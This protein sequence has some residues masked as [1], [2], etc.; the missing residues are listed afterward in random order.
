M[1]QNV[2]SGP[3][4]L[5]FTEACHGIRPSF[6]AVQGLQTLCAVFFGVSGA[7][8]HASCLSNYHAS[9]VSPRAMH[10]ARTLLHLATLDRWH[11]YCI[12][13]NH[14]TGRLHRTTRIVPA[15]VN[16]FPSV[17]YGTLMLARSLLMRGRHDPC[18]ARVRHLTQGSIGR[19]APRATRKR[20]T[21]HCTAVQA[22]LRRNELAFGTA[23]AL[24]LR[25]PAHWTTL[26]RQGTQTTKPLTHTEANPQ[27]YQPSGPS[28]AHTRTPRHGAGTPT[29]R[30]FASLGTTT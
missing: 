9:P 1:L 30:P 12:S 10:L 19:K 28:G 26:Q 25:C 6:W 14:A 24:V 11:G 29:K 13:T 21:F 7:P 8:W 16:S 23:P 17:P 27:T 3:L 15:N 20:P 4:T 18:Y 2:G 22:P 5:K